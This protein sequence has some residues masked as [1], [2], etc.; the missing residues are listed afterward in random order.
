MPDPRS[1]PVGRIA[2]VGAGVL[3]TVYGAKLALAG[4]DVTMIER[5]PARLEQIRSRGLEIETLKGTERQT[6]RVGVMDSLDLESPFELAIVIARKTHLPGILEML[7]KTAIPTVLI[8]ASN[9]E[10]PD[11]IVRW[12]GSRAVVG[13][14]GA[15][16]R[17]VNG[18][19]QFSVP[20]KLMQP[21]MLGEVDGRRSDRVLALKGL[22]ESGG[23][24]ATVSEEMDAWLKS[25]EAFVATTGNATYV[26]GSGSALGADGELLELNIR[27]IREIYAAMDAAGIPILPRWFRLWQRLPLPIIRAT[28]SKFIGSAAWDDLGSDQLRSMRDEVEVISVELITFA[29]EH[30]VATPALAELISRRERLA[31]S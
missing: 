23:F 31:A 17:L 18:V 24:H 7:S 19:V 2:V 12:L 26:A 10:G 14:P 13:F 29:A 3:G 9:A 22:L 8:M 21:T 27:A 4:H 5:S 1:S 11:E 25:H 28:Y 15:G 16:G 6:V 30:G 20:P